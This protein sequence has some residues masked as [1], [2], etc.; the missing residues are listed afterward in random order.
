M[1]EMD[2]SEYLAQNSK[3]NDRAKTRSRTCLASDRR[4]SENPEL[5]RAGDLSERMPKD[6]PPSCQLIQD[7]QE[8]PG[9]SGPAARKRRACEGLKRGP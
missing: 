2:Q 8:F 1:R 9:Q 7:T 6:A 5:P 4:G 3:I